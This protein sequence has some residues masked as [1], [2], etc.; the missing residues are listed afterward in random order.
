MKFPLDGRPPLGGQSRLARAVPFNENLWIG[1]VVCALIAVAGFWYGGWWT[2]QNHL[3]AD[4][5]QE[6]LATVTHK[7]VVVTQGKHGPIHTPHL[8]YH[9]HVRDV[10]VDCDVSTQWTLYN[11]VVEGG[12]MPIKYLPE[13]PANNRLDDTGDDYQAKMKANGGLIAG[14]V[15]LVFA[16]ASAIGADRRKKL[17]TRL[18]TAGLSTVGRVT[19]VETERAGKTTVTFLRLEFTDNSGQVI[20]GRT[21]RLTPKQKRIWNRG[22]KIT[23]YY[24]SRNS[25]VFTTNLNASKS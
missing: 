22:D 19:S 14:L 13:D 18:K 17:L 3:Y 7:Y 2:W 20:S 16:I 10:A 1:T 15:A 6:M 11:A 24:D 23:I 9:Y 21:G 5:G 8:Q 4:H 12:G 25:S